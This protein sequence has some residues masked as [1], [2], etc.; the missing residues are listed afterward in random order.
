MKKSRIHTRVTLK[1]IQC[2][3]RLKYEVIGVINKFAFDFFINKSGFSR[4]GASDCQV[5]RKTF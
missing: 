5:W 4:Y 1:A 3:A 2:M